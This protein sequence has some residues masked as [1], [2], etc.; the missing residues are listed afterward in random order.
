MTRRC[1]IR[2]KSYS[3]AS[4]ART[5]SLSPIESVK[6]RQKALWT[7]RLLK[8]E[9]VTPSK[10][11]SEFTGRTR[12]FA[13]TEEAKVSVTS[14]RKRVAREC[15]VDLMLGSDVRGGRTADN[16]VVCRGFALLCRVS[17]EKQFRDGIKIFSDFLRL[18][19]FEAQNASD[20]SSSTRVGPSFEHQE[21]NTRASQVLRARGGGEP[22]RRGDDGSE[23]ARRSHQV[24]ARV[25]IKS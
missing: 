19:L 23:T 11:T 9:V 21:D 13:S 22:H 7:S 17:R 5:F 8:A 20:S 15:R 2:V 4:R 12:T 18:L 3:G 16:A 24:R 1:A 14:T 10:S 25:R 6:P